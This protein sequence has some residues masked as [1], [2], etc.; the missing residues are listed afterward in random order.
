MDAGV[1]S[2]LTV[3]PLWI[4]LFTVA[5]NARAIVAVS[6][7]A[8]TAN[9]SCTRWPQAIC[10]TAYVRRQ[11]CANSDSPQD[12]RGCA[13]RRRR[14]EAERTL[15]W[16]ASSSAT[17]FSCEYTQHVSSTA[18]K[19][20]QLFHTALRVKPALLPVLL[21]V[22]QKWGRHRNGRPPTLSL[23]KTLLTGL[24]RP[25]THIQYDMV[26][27][28][29]VRVQGCYVYDLIGFPAGRASTETTGN[30]ERTRHK[31]HRTACSRRR[32]MNTNRRARLAFLTKTFSI[33]VFP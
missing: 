27:R 24:K 15:L 3:G 4:S 29:R 23:N 1:V 22:S 21:C 7:P 5:T 32:G 2:W 12:G 20:K 16:L 13:V 26:S 9:A 25:R 33:L 6:I 8:L 19:T 31:R 11:M 14:R 17:T 10:V 18:V 30:P 28:V